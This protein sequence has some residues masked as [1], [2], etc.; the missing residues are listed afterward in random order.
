MKTINSLLIFLFLSVINLAQISDFT[1]PTPELQNRN[2][3]SWSYPL[4]GPTGT[5]KML[6]VYCKF[7]DDNFNLSPH[8]DL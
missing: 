3:M 5:L 4:F 7:S 2:N 1:C 8:T 6:V